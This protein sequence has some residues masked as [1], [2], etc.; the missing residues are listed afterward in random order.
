MEATGKAEPQPGVSEAS[1][2]AEKLPCVL[3]SKAVTISNPIRE[4]SE[5]A[6]IDKWINSNLKL[7]WEFYVDILETHK[8]CWP[9]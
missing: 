8:G 4:K 1:G 9:T 6:Q 5:Y 2:I 3:W 7:V